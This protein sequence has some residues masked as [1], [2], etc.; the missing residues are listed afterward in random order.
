M[1][2]LAIKTG[3]RPLSVHYDN[4]WNTSIATQNI[5]AMVS[6]LNIDLYTY[7]VDAQEQDQILL[8]FMQKT[9]SILRAQISNCLFKD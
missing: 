6:K 3:L 5:K 9:A 4:T 7:V 1:V 8:S 2:Y